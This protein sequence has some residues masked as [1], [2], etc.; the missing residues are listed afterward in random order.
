MAKGERKKENESLLERCI[1]AWNDELCAEHDGTIKSFE[2]FGKKISCLNEYT[3]FLEDNI[4][5]RI[6]KIF[7]AIVAAGLMV[8]TGGLSGGVF[9]ILGRGLGSAVGL[10]ASELLGGTALTAILASKLMEDD[11][12]FRIHK[13]L[14]SKGSHCVVYVN[15]FL[16]EKETTFSDWLEGELIDSKCL[17]GITWGNKELSDLLIPGRGFVSSNPWSSA[18]KNAENAGLILGDAISRVEGVTFTLVGHSLGCRVIKH[19]LK[20][21]LAGKHSMVRDVI[22]LGGAVRNDSS[23]WEELLPVVSGNVY[24]CHSEN[25]DVLKILYQVAQLGL[26][27][28]IGRYPIKSQSSKIV[29]VPCDFV[30][31]HMKWKDNYQSILHEI[32]NNFSQPVAQSVERVDRDVVQFCWANS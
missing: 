12:E 22:L 1:P 20:A 28:P 13:L 6:K 29:D 23:K 5:N 27:S 16:Q 3:E 30:K 26:D 8:G 10:G 25:D 9:T 32:K 4:T 31:S 2:M 17:Y 7:P 24:N 14:K 19:T 21:L 15:G 18:V 11:R